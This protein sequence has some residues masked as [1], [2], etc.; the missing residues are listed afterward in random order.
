MVSVK[1]EVSYVEKRTFYGMPY[2][3]LNSKR[4]PYKATFLLPLQTCLK[5]LCF[6]CRLFHPRR[7]SFL[8]Y[9]PKAVVVWAHQR[10]SQ[11]K[12]YVCAL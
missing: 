10:Y 5:R 4:L 11:A 3:F 12:L 2:G 7:Y 6:H 9:V 1:G 8:E